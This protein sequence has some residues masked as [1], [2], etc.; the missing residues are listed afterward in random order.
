MLPREKRTQEFKHSLLP[1]DSRPR[2][3]KKPWY[4]SLASLS[5]ACYCAWYQEG[6]LE[7]SSSLDV[8]LARSLRQSLFKRFLILRVRHGEN[9]FS[10][11][12]HC[13]GE[14]SVER[15]LGARA[16]NRRWTCALREQVGTLWLQRITPHKGCL[17]QVI[18]K[19]LAEVRMERCKHFLSWP[20][21]NPKA[22]MQPDC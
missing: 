19:G 18:A 17:R 9:A 2:I 11:E 8:I 14:G 4:R 3:H 5:E 13:S 6:K 20:R 7:P 21:G 15:N 22:I 1:L 12:P 10:V 16:D